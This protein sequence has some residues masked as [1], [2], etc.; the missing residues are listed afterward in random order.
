MNKCL[1]HVGNAWLMNGKN[2]N[3]L[4]QIKTI[5]ITYVA[6]VH[7]EKPAHLGSLIRV[8]TVCVVPTDAQAYL[9]VPF[10]AYVIRSVSIWSASNDYGVSPDSD[11]HIYVICTVMYII[12]A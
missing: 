3:V 6:C 8:Y 4:L 1:F 5:F 9:S 12:V 7:A 10:F 2:V 11:E